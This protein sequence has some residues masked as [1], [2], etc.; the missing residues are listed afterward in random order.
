MAVYSPSTILVWNIAAIEAKSGKSCE[1]D[2]AHL[3][4]GVCK[5][6]DLDPERFCPRPIRRDRVQ[7]EEFAT[8]IETLRQ[9]F[10]AWGLD[11]TQFR[12]RLRSAIARSESERLERGIVH[13][14]PVSRRVFERAEEIAMLGTD[15][16]PILR[17]CH[18]L[19]AILELPASPW[20]NLLE[21]MGVYNLET[22][23]FDR[24]D[25]EHQ[26]EQSAPVWMEAEPLFPPQSQED[27]PFLDCFGRDLSQMARDG[28]LDPTI[29]RHAEINALASILMQ[30]RKCNAILVGEAGV[31]KTCIV[32]GLA[33]W[34]ENAVIPPVLQNKRVVE[35]SMAGL[36]AGSKYRGEF[37]ERMQ[38][39]IS[40]AATANDVILFIDEIHTVLGAGGGGASDA[41]NILKPALARGE[42][43]C[44]GATTVRE[45]RATIETDTALERRF[46]T[47]WVNEPSPEE[48]IDILKGLR[49][50]FEA[51]HNAIVSDT[52]IESAVEL[53]ERYLTDLHQPDKSID[54]IDRACA[55]VR[56]L[57]AGEQNGTPAHCRIGE[58]E[59]L[60]V[61]SQR[62]K[63]PIERLTQNERSRLL[64]LEKILRERVMGQDEAI[65]TV[66]NA[67][68]TARAGL[69]DPNKPI[70]VFL[71]VGLTGTGKT[72]LAKAL[73]QC[74]FDDERQLI[75]VDMSEYMEPHTVSRLTGAPPG[76]VGYDR[77][78]QLTKAVRS[79]PYSVVLFDEVEKAHP[80]V[81]DLFLQIFD[82]GHLTDSHGRHISF[83]DTAIVLTSNLGTQSFHAARSLG[84]G[85]GDD[86]AQIE[87]SVYQRQIQDAL[88]QSLRPELL[89]RLSQVVWFYPL[90]AEVVR[91]IIDKILTNLH[92]RLEAQKL[93]LKLT[94]NAYEF[95]MEKGYNAQFGAREMERTIDRF[96]IQ[97]LG[98]ALLSEKFPPGTTILAEAREE[99]LVLLAGERVTVNEER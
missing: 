96:L 19:Q 97:P 82:E 17:P 66:S 57:V 47:I 2:P 36:L 70:G 92:P 6:C 91:Q 54:L 11:Q 60:S 61:V 53:A 43:Q 32:E 1:I 59:I 40:E 93:F 35:I 7:K 52:A 8:D 81:L 68:R 62:C 26:R 51:H 75:R 89:N 27:T 4:L 41:A 56:L 88:Q 25:S 99:G 86:R 21:E 73:A 80:K 63:L 23:P 48:T 15:D 16:S 24:T 37:E 83:K 18:L 45:Y 38:A 55:D 9:W 13:R 20:E 44:V 29:G 33:Q 46:Q 58:T 95:L 42:I 76:Y 85:F 28:Q 12:R 10:A 78:G 65:E 67:I 77:E 79:K 87:R 69:K 64:G 34:L 98:Q 84:F 71:F 3:L 5:L 30:R 90:S 31:G 49:P 94:D 50:Q 74:L 39:L 22:P 14:S 72:E